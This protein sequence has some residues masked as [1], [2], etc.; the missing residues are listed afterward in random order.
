V[1]KAA[2]AGD[3]PRPLGIAVDRISLE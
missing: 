2:G 3:D 1:P